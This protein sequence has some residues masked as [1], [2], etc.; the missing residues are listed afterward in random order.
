MSELTEG[1]DRS[2]VRK[3]AHGEYGEDDGAWISLLAQLCWIILVI[4]THQLDYCPKSEGA[5]Q[6]NQSVRSPVCVTLLHQRTLQ[7]LVLE[8]TPRTE[9][10]K[11]RPRGA[12]V[13]R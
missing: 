4:R 3:E 7:Y 11:L 12:H 1:N 9:V 13:A 5:H 6:I 8:V 10:G 2:Q